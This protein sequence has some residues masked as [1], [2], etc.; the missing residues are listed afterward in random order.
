MEKRIKRRGEGQKLR[1]IKERIQG[2]EKEEIRVKKDISWV[3]GKMRYPEIEPM[4][5]S[6]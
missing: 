6:Y 1:G 4:T 2:G 5:F 3:K